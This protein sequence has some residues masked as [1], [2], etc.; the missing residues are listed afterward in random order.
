MGDRHHLRVD[1]IRRFA[2]PTSVIDVSSRM[3]TGWKAA[4]HMRTELPEPG[5][6]YTQP[7]GLIEMRV[8]DPDGIP[9]RGSRGHLS[10]V[11]GATAGTTNRTRITAHSTETRQPSRP[12]GGRSGQSPRERWCINIRI[13]HSHVG[14]FLEADNAKPG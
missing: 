11:P 13:G 2:L 14:R 6:G 5:S 8:E 4:E 7:W 3:I 10:A 9:I 12:V 1:L